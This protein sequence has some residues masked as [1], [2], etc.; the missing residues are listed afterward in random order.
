MTE[1]IKLRL[2]MRKL[3]NGGLPFSDKAWETF[4]TILKS[5]LEGVTKR[6]ESGISYVSVEVGRAYKEDVYEY[7]MVIPANRL[8]RIDRLIRPARDIFGWHCIR[9]IATDVD[10]KGISLRYDN[11]IDRDSFRIE[12]KNRDHGITGLTLPFKSDSF[13]A[14]DNLYNQPVSPS[15][16]LGSDSPFKSVEFNNGDPSEHIE[17]LNTHC[18]CIIIYGDEPMLERHAGNDVPYL[19]DCCA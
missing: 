14:L 18:E 8:K 16:L 6:D 9:R 2:W 4:H 3:H 5:S 1:D 13:A 7:E 10:A 11:R 15:L 19:S 12:M 17:W